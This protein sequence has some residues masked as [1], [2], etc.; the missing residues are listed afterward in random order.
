MDRKFEFDWISKQTIPIYGIC[1]LIRLYLREGK[2]SEREQKQS[3]T[4]DIKGNT[5][6]E[7]FTFI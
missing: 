7:Y 6:N 3:W 1:F 5:L 4:K 2:R